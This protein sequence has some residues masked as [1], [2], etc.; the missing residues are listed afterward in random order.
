MEIDPGQ[1][2]QGSIPFLYSCINT[3][4]KV[5]AT[6]WVSETV[7]FFFLKWQ[8]RWYSTGR[9]KQ[10]SLYF[11]VLV[12]SASSAAEPGLW[13]LGDGAQPVWRHAWQPKPERVPC[14]FF[15][16]TLIRRPRSEDLKK[17]KWF[18]K[19]KNLF[20]YSYSNYNQYV[21]IDAWY[22]RT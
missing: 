9:R 18:Y 21:A 7:Y 17:T 15:P 22:T 6:H 10:R 20:K 3:L 11:S 13:W 19:T 2:T 16:K 12:L 14:H 8:G 5:V 4:G 1:G